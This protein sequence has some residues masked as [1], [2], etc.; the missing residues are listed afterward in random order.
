M[1][2]IAKLILCISGAKQLWL[3]AIIAFIGSLASI[4]LCGHSQVGK[5][6][7]V[8][9][10]GI[11]FQGLGAFVGIV[12]AAMAIVYDRLRDYQFSFLT[13]RDFLRV[14]WENQEIPAAK[15]IFRSAETPPRLWEALKRTMGMLV[16]TSG[17]A[18][19][20]V[21]VSLNL[22]GGQIMPVNWNL[23]IMAI[24]SALTL[25]AIIYSFLAMLFVIFDFIYS[26]D[27]A[28][29]LGYITQL[30]ERTDRW[31]SRAEQLTLVKLIAQF[32]N[33]IQ[34]PSFNLGELHRM[35]LVPV[36]VLW[37]SLN[38]R[39]GYGL[40]KQILEEDAETRHVRDIIEICIFSSHILRFIPTTAPT[41]QIDLFKEN[42][43]RGIVRRKFSYSSLEEERSV[44]VLLELIHFLSSCPPIVNRIPITAMLVHLR[45]TDIGSQ[46]AFNCIAD[47]LEECIRP[48]AFEREELVQDLARAILEIAD[49]FA[50]VLDRD[51][52]F[53][54]L[55]RSILALFN[56]R[57]RE[58]YSAIRDRARFC[59]PRGQKIVLEALRQAGE[60]SRE[61]EKT[62]GYILTICTTTTYE[63]LAGIA[64]AF[65]HQMLE[66]QGF[67]QEIYVVR[68]LILHPDKHIRMATAI[69]LQSEIGR[70]DANTFARLR[71]LL[72]HDP[73]DEVRRFVESRFI[74]SQA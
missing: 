60:R 72:L 32:I 70:Y 48:T 27:I 34:A 58:L 68:K 20:V 25:A 54:A 71:K 62:L 23:L 28:E 69:L 18:M 33:R 45:N 26:K 73:S 22:A 14:Y 53:N 30:L 36:F 50:E 35:E 46:I 10:L 12:L 2:R 40:F 19:T 31:F 16:L 15:E 24:A 43:I 41:S 51:E 74:Q 13:V 57:D 65:A 1:N 63:E 55:L 59:T 5:E 67:P 66:A 38:S 42:F 21:L 29:D 39:R 37:V 64:L 44:T 6:T 3:I 52:S 4:P 17:L 61:V 47:S 9:I 49:E 8:D 7:T 56:Y 11:M